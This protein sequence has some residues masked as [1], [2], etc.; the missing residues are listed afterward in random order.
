MKKAN[1]I[2]ESF[3]N[4]NTLDTL[5]KPYFSLQFADTIKRYFNTYFESSV[6]V[7]TSLQT[8]SNII[9]NG[10]NLATFFK[11]ALKLDRGNHLLNIHME[12]IAGFKLKITV[13]AEGGLALGDKDE[14]K[15]RAIARISRFDLDIQNGSLILIQKMEA[16]TSIP[17]NA[18]YHTSPLFDEFKRA[19]AN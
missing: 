7:T 6:T 13:S 18:M 15:L 11:E 10:Y 16:V 8:P 19:F 5:Q 1:F 12:E 14:E 4:L 17:V 9:T 2:N 3:K